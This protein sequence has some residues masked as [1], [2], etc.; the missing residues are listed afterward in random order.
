M[1]T[2]SNK[3]TALKSLPLAAMSLATVLMATEV[4]ADSR[5]Y[6]EWD[7]YQTA[8][9]KQWSNPNRDYNWQ[10]RKSYRASKS[11]RLE[12]N[13]RRNFRNE[14]IAL[15]RTMNIGSD[16]RGHRVE[17]IVITTKPRK[18]RGRLRLMVNGRAVDSERVGNSYKVRLT[19][20]SRTVIGKT[21]RSLQL[22]VRGKVFIK[23]IRVNLTKPKSRRQVHSRHSE[24]T[25]IRIPAESSST[26]HDNPWVIF[27]SV[28]NSLPR[29]Y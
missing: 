4:S 28:L 10:D 22:G 12:R 7:G 5:R 8:K 9:A 18:S 24:P 14:T 17:S 29:N 15:R 27:N 1:L 6:N 26:I 19:P 16:Y 21:V 2:K 13:I 20:Q 23:D 25:V 11:V 3:A